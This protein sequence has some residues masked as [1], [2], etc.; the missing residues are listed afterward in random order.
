MPTELDAIITNAAGCGAMLKD[1]G[2]LLHDTPHAEAGEQFA[3]KVRD[4]SEFLVDLGP[5]AADAPAADHGDLPRR[6]P[7]APRP[8]DPQAAAA[9]PGDDPRA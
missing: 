4:I 3:A 5:V 9:A 7:P 2:H 6:L 1:Y 8:A